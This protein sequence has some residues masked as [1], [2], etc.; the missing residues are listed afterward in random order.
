[1]YSYTFGLLRRCSIIRFTLRRANIYIG[2]FLKGLSHLLLE[3]QVRGHVTSFVD[4][5]Y[6]VIL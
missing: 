2:R 5:S 1:M 3:L 4:Q 6:Y